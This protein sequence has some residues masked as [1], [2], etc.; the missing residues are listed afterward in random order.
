LV[1]GD[2]DSGLGL[3]NDFAITNADNVGSNVLHVVGTLSNGNYVIDQRINGSWTVD[4]RALV[5]TANNL[6]KIVNASDPALTWTTNGNLVNGDQL[7]G[8][9]TRSAGET[10]GQYRIEQGSLNN[11]NYAIAF[12]DG[13]FNIGIT[14]LNQLLSAPEN[15]AAVTTKP[16]RELPTPTTSLAVQL[17]SNN[18]YSVIEQ[19]LR[20]PEGL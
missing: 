6:G 5:V 9:L 20:L 3:R 18:L 8:N 12:T 17:P 13:A 4:P 11:S 14:P 15:V 1:N 7:N 10:V 19:G 16:L 2:L